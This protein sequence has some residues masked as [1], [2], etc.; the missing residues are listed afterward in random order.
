MQNS[1][2]DPIIIGI[3]NSVELFK[4]DLNHL[5]TFSSK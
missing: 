3:A 4:G 1:K 5:N 2:F